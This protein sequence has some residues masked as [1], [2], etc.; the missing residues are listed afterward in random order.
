M[1]HVACP[2]C[3]NNTANQP[4]WKCKECGFIGC[5][6]GGF[7]TKGCWTGNC[8]KCNANSYTCIGYVG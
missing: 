8:P 4:I 6:G 5:A 3:L 7:Y 2:N 1:S